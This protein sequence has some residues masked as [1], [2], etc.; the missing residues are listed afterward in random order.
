MIPSNALYALFN[1]SD[2]NCRLLD[3]STSSHQYFF[4]SVAQADWQENFKSLE[5]KTAVRRL[6]EIARNNEM[7]LAPYDVNTGTEAK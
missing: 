2:N 7:Y 1:Q 6:S 5:P 4:D 3:V